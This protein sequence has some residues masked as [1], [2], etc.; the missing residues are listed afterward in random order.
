MLM[1]RKIILTYVVI[2]LIALINALNYELFIFP[3]QF[4]PA[5]LNGICTMIQYVFHISVGYMSLLINIPLAIWV[6]FKVSRPLAV[7]SLVY[8]V[9]FSLALLAL[10][11]I[12]I[13]EFVYVTDNGTSTV[14]GPLVAGVIYGFCYSMLVRASAYT[15]GTDFVAAA[16]H[17]Y[18]PEKSIFGLIF[19]INAIVAMASYFVYD[20]KIEPVILCIMYSFTSSTIS[21][22]QMRSGRSA[23]RFEIMTE[24]PKEISDEIIHH[25]NHSATLLPGKGM[26]L[27]K[28]TSVLVCVVNNT[29]AAALAAIVRRYPHTFSVVSQVREVVGNFKHMTNDG[30]IAKDF[31]DE[32]D[33]KAV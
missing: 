10:D 5:G 11:Q 21:E 17:K 23:L 3:N 32:G 18:H 22:R 8:V 16:I 30:K 13:S 19:L 31:L 9:V 2:V 6:Y 7:R 1:K 28:E 25:L 27:G 33:G 12:D 29:Q 15:G 20:Y 26:Y 4:A 14:L 24:Y